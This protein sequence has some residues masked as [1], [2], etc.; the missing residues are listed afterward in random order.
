[1]QPSLW[2]DYI[3]LDTDERRRFAQVSHEYLIEQ[4][5]TVNLGNPTTG[6]YAGNYNINLNHPVKELIIT[7]R[8]V[9][10]SA[11]AGATLV[12]NNG[13]VD[14]RTELGN[15]NHGLMYGPSPTYVEDEDALL[16]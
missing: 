15:K 8:P 10:P 3:Y 7:G 9:N 13:A 14:A 1:M 4:V 16:L 5:Q 2:A 12:D 11:A 6:S